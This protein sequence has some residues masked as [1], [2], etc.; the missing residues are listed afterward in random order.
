MNPWFWGPSFMETHFFLHI[1]IYIWRHGQNIAILWAMVI[2]PRNGNEAEYN[3]EKNG[4]MTTFPSV[5]LSL[6]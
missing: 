5:T 2:H 6:G 4:L 3:P 1:Y